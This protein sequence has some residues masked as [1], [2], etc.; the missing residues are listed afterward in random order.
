M[1]THT[2]KWK[3]SSA[4]TED[5]IFASPAACDVFLTVSK[6]GDPPPPIEVQVNGVVVPNGAMTR[7]E[8]SRTFRFSEVNTIHI[9][10]GANPFPFGATGEYLIT[11]EQPRTH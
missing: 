7:G 3:V 9:I 5:L 6:T 1:E 10:T 11:F 4:E 8:L 2:G